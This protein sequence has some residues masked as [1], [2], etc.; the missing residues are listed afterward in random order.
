MPVDPQA[1]AILLQLPPGGL[2]SDTSLTPQQLRE[3]AGALVHKA[4]ACASALCLQRCLCQPHPLTCQ[5][6]GPRAG[7]ALLMPRLASSV[8]ITS[9]CK[10]QH[11]GLMHR[12]EG[13]C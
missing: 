4:F 11:R 7:H 2:Y 13:P 5:K 9:S 8:C 10:S 6:S 3:R 1:A 12:L